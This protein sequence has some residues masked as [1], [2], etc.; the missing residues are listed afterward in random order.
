MIR[1]IFFT[2]FITLSIN[3]GFSFVEKK[4]F[5]YTKKTKYREAID[6]HCFDEIPESFFTKINNVKKCIEEKQTNCVYSHVDK[7]W[8]KY[9]RLHDDYIF[10]LIKKNKFL[11]DNGVVLKEKWSPLK[12][13]K[14]KE[15][16]FITFVISKVFE[17]TASDCHNELSRAKDWRSVRIYNEDTFYAPVIINVKTGDFL[18]FGSEHNLVEDKYNDRKIVTNGV[19]DSRDE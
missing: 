17:L 1:V 3:S 19:E 6:Y 8:Q 12:L 2:L 13:N 18:F 11:V 5:K 14:K 15:I 9:I 16:Q 10:D 4:S 7:N